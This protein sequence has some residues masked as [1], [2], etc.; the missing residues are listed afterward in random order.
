MI[1]KGKLNNPCV[2]NFQSYHCNVS[3]H[4]NSTSDMLN[5]ALNYHLAIDWITSNQELNLHKYEL[6]DDEWAIAENLW[7]TL[8]VHID[9]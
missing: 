9:L 7:D 8:K 4:W 1:L 6:E 5:F 2:F 3:T